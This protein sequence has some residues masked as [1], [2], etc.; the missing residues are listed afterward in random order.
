MKRRFAI[1]RPIDNY[2]D[3]GLKMNEAALSRREI[4]IDDEYEERTRT[5]SSLPRWSAPGRLVQL[6]LVHKK[7]TQV[8]VDERSPLSDN[9]TYTITYTVKEGIQKGV[10]KTVTCP[11]IKVRIPR[12][13]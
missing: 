11:T 2:I 6:E 13:N 12:A 10:Q 1:L 5:V 7:W 8:K 4:D 9:G 3:E